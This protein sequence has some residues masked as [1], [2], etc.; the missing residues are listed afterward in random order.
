VAEH[1]LLDF[2]PFPRVWRKVS[3]LEDETQFI[4][5]PLQLKLPCPSEK[6]MIPSA[7]TSMMP[8]L[9]ANTA[10]GEAGRGSEN[11]VPFV[12]ALSLDDEGHPSRIKLTPV[13]G[14][15]NTGPLPTGL[16]PILLRVAQCFLIA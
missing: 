13:S 14:F 6:Q 15:T 5:K 12:A 16:K 1:A 4:G 7:A 3:Y 9:A 11:K 8:I 2:I 10:G